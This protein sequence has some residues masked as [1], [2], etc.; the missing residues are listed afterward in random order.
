MARLRSTFEGRPSIPR[1]ECVPFRVVARLQQGA[2]FDERWPQ[3]LDGL[4]SRL[5][6]DSPDSPMP[7]DEHRA[8]GGHLYNAHLPFW[9]WAA[10]SQRETRHML[11]A[12]QK[13]WWVWRA[14]CARPVGPAD[15][16]LHWEHRRFDHVNAERTADV[17]FGLRE[18]QGAYRDYRIPRPVTVTAD[19]E[20]HA[21]GDPDQTRRLL[22]G[23]W[24]IGKKA[25]HGEGAV[26]DWDV[27]HVDV[28]DDTETLW[29]LWWPDTRTPARP[30]PAPDQAPA[31]WTCT[32]G[33]RPPYWH[34]ER[35]RSCWHPEAR[36]D[37]IMEWATATVDS[38]GD[39]GIT[40]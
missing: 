9:G 21:F 15:R 32:A 18:W 19:V 10:N 17:P 26:I 30:L 33:I 3:M 14:S 31:E 37:D 13:R 29:G 16:E 12:G 20:W 8:R 25:A 40:A 28:D 4:I 11:R 2:I 38:K 6:L 34:P 27:Q 7:W 5:Y 23:C 22:A 35:Q 24:A 36:Y 39:P 1:D